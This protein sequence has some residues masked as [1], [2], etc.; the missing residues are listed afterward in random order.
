MFLFLYPVYLS[1]NNNITL[2]FQTL[3]G[4]QDMGARPIAQPRVWH[5]Y[6]PLTKKGATRRKQKIDVASAE[7]N[8]AL[9]GCSLVKSGA[10]ERSLRRGPCMRRDRWMRK[11]YIPDVFIRARPQRS[12]FLSH[13]PVGKENICD[14]RRGQGG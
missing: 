12:I 13:I 11:H 6:R 9:H 10:A 7:I 1:Y 3:G 5:E 2:S 8:A 4:P 14:P